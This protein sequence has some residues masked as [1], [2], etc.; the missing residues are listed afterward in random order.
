MSRLE[1]RDDVL[2]S[3][4]YDYLM[5]TGVVVVHGR[6]ILLRSECTWPLMG[7]ARVPT[8]SYSHGLLRAIRV[9]RFV[10][11]SSGLFQRSGCRQCD[12]PCYQCS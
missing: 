3:T 8:P 11:R 1:H 9:E 10:E 6:R 7:N 4:L 2:L 5:A 12:R